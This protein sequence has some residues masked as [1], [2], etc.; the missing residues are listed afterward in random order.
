MSLIALVAAGLVTGRLRGARLQRGLPRVSW[1]PIVLVS[2]AGIALTA[3]FLEALFRTAR[4]N[5]LQEYDAW[6]FWVPKAK[7]IFFFDGLDS[8]VFTT[9][10]TRRTR[11]S[12][13]SSMR[14]PS[15]RWAGRTSSPCTCS[16][17]SSSSARSP[18]SPGCSI[19]MHRRGFLAA[20]PARARGAALRR[21]AAG[22]PGRRPAGRSR[23]RRRPAPGPVA[24]RPGRLAA[25]GGG[26]AA[27]RRRE[28]EARRDSSLRP[29][30]LRPRSSSHDHGS[31]HGSPLHP[32]SWL[33]QSSRGGSGRAG[34]TS[35]PGRRR[36]R[37]AAGGS[38]ALST[39][40]STFS[41]RRALVGASG[42]RD[43]RR[44]CGSVW[45]DRR[46]AGFVGL[47]ALLFFAGGVWST[48]GFAELAIS[49]DESGNPIVRYTGSIIFLAAAALPLLLAS[50]WRRNEEP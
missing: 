18:R 14:P 16:S 30:C 44:R 47:V 50:V 1:T 45:G 35:P 39:S 12:S 46:L 3:L 15:M 8:H 49:A 9:A 24:P 17:G 31:G 28:H 36:R 22:A 6:A 42:H 37:S 26:S 13:P 40:R 34:T 27:R 41:T 10:P 5:S 38:E 29:A 48:A 43:D 32:S 2:A 25:R 21:A 4:L 23:R 20:A 19:G 11:P 7:A 33:S